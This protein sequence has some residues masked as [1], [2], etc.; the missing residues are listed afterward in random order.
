MK[1]MKKLMLLVITIGLSIVAQAQVNYDVIVKHTG[2]KLEVKVSLVDDEKIT[3]TY[4][5]ENVL[6]TI[7]KNCV[8]QIIFSSGR[9]QECSAKITVKGI[10]DWEKVIITTN[11]DDVKGLIRKGEVSSSASNDWN[12]KSKEGIDKKATMKIKKKAAAM[13]GHIIFLQDQRKKN[14]TLIS[15][16]S[17]DKYGVVYGYE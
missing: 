7:G 1:K 13:Y 2:E 12:F 15:G 8:K 4:L 6:L 9:V 11:L 17:S 16:A 14:M 10:N 3:Y 5:N